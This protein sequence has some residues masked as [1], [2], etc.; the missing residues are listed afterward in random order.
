[1]ASAIVGYRFSIVS[2]QQLSVIIVGSVLTTSTD[3]PP[4]YNLWHNYVAT[5]IVYVGII[6]TCMHVQ[7]KLH[8]SF[9]QFLASGLAQGPVARQGRG[10]DTFSWQTNFPPSPGHIILER[11]VYPVQ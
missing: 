11:T 6:A 8:H 9:N 10:P 3:N 4:R 1:M 2:L 5:Y 7:V